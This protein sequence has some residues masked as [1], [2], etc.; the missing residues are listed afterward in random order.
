M[1]GA[2]LRYTIHDILDLVDHALYI[3]LH[4]LRIKLEKKKR[5][6]YK[7]CIVINSCESFYVLYSKKKRFP[8]DIYNPN[9]SNITIIEQKRTLWI[10]ISYNKY[11]KKW[12]KVKCNFSWP[13]LFTV[14]SQVS[15]LRTCL[16]MCLKIN[17]HTQHVIFYSFLVTLSTKL[18]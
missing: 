16:K 3:T 18:W 17:N 15:A 13:Q 14:V 10:F 11:K 5:K 6:Q 9:Y 8:F 12:I 4:G 2:K 1:E 7:R